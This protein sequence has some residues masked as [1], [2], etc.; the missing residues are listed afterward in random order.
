MQLTTLALLL[1]PPLSWAAAGDVAARVDRMMAE[2]YPADGPGAVV[3]A[4][5]Q[6]DVVVRASYGR[7]NLEHDL[8]MHPEGVFRIASVAKLFTAT[9][10]LMLA[11]DGELGLDDAITKYLPDYPTQG[12]EITVRHL[13]T[14]TSGIAEVLDREDA[15]EWIRQDK[16]VEELIDSFA[17]R[18]MA[19][20][21]GQASAYSN[22]NYVLLA[23]IVA[24]VSGETYAEFV[25]T[26]IFEPAGMESTLLGGFPELVPGRVAGYEPR[27]DG[28][29]NEKYYS[30]TI[31]YGSGDALS[32]ADDLH[33]WVRG[34][35]RRRLRLGG[36]A[37]ALLRARAT[38]ERRPHALR[39]G[40][41]ARPGGG[42][43]RRA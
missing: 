26:R 18:E 2:L 19:F 16:S 42:A 43:P 12:V 24:R 31:L 35:L 30:M 38:G 32:T 8:P 10:V 29:V 9:A 6:G 34:V 28:F 25:R 37:R 22:S 23:A 11:E 15:R 40:L 27:G 36:D 33:R 4:S 7:A 17:H 13:L 5:R 3:L 20:R 41:G 14:H 1:S 21:P 39:P